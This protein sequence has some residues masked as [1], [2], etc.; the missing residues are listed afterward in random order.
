MI[1][2]KVDTFSHKLQVI[3]STKR[4]KQAFPQK[5][6][7]IHKESEKELDLYEYKIVLVLREI[8]K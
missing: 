7:K 8:W 2:L 5:Y 6:I 1:S 3:N 4:N